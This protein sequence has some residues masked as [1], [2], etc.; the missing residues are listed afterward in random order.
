[1]PVCLEQAA[2]RSGW[3]QQMA[4]DAVAHRQIIAAAWG[5]LQSGP[6]SL[7]ADGKLTES[8]PPIAQLIEKRCLYLRAHQ[9]IGGHLR[10]MGASGVLLECTV[11]G[12]GG[13]RYVSGG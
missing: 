8:A 9:L 3:V 13:S 2:R 6:E 11:F 7:G 10:D 4:K 5:A 12:G 1:M